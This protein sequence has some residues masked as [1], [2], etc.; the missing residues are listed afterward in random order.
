MGIIYSLVIGG[1]AGFLAGKIMRGRGYGI[2][3]DI[4]L[5]I[6]GGWLGGFVFGLLGLASFGLLGSLIT[7]TIGAVLLIFLIRLIR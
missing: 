5:G 7:S 1:I 2:L 6:V 4:V 3:M